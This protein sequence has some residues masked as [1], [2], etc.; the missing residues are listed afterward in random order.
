MR[1]RLIALVIGLAM[2]ALAGGKGIATPLDQDAEHLAIVNSEGWADLYFSALTAAAFDN[3]SPS[4]MPKTLA[5]LEKSRYMLWIPKPD[6]KV[7]D[8]SKTLTGG[9]TFLNHDLM[10]FEADLLKRKHRGDFALKP[11]EMLIAYSDSEM[12]FA[13]G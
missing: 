13:A 1:T 9:R 11:G 3:L 12:L 4:G 8:V 6:F 10:D 2:L 5:D 7:T